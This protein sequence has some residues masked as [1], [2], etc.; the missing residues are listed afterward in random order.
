MLF[1]AKYKALKTVANRKQKVPIIN[2]DYNKS[3][4]YNKNIM[5]CIVC[6][7]FGL[8]IVSFPSQ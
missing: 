1:I 8:E 7:T 6:L 4:K 5:I 2:S 3:V